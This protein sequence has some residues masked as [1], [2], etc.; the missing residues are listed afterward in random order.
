MAIADGTPTAVSSG[1]P[2]TPP[3]EGADAT[4]TATTTA[5]AEGTPADVGAT[6]TAETDDE[7]R[8][9]PGTTPTTIDATP[10]DSAL[11]T[12]TTKLPSELP[13]TGGNAGL[14]TGWLAFGLVVLLVAAGVAAL[15]KGASGQGLR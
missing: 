8:G 4:G 2:G 11:T 3:G 7:I 1:T 6:S 12:P 14:G 13:V 15:H 5:I 9:T 10:T